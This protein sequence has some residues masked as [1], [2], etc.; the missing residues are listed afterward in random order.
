MAARIL[1]ANQTATET[2][3]IVH[4]D[5]ARVTRDGDPDPTYVKRFAWPLVD[6][7]NLAETRSDYIARIKQEARALARTALDDIGADAVTSLTGEML[8]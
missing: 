6:P 7:L 5:T 8:D 1:K 4:L 3:L 2:V